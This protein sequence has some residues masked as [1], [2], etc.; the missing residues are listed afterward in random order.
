MQQTHP[1]FDLSQQIPELY[2][3]KE[4][5]DVTADLTDA[6][7]AIIA[8]ASLMLWNADQMP[9]IIGIAINYNI[10]PSQEVL[11]EEQLTMMREQ[12]LRHDPDQWPTTDIK[13]ILFRQ[14]GLYGGASNLLQSMMEAI[15][16]NAKD[17]KEKFRAQN[18]FV[19]HCHRTTKRVWEY[20]PA[21]RILMPKVRKIVGMSPFF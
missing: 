19:L 10:G 6:K 16:D 9:R 17:M 3:A 8:G 2:S 1:F 14:M 11:L 20:I 4:R 18:D 15:E 21:D 13:M 7:T 12:M 5:L